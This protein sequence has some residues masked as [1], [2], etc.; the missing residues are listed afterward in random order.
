MFPLFFYYVTTTFLF[1]S[2]FLLFLDVRVISYSQV[3]VSL[4]LFFTAYPHIWSANRVYYSD[5][6]SC[7]Y[8]SS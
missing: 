1:N 7:L 8:H 2:Q 3:L 5:L 4:L 6:L